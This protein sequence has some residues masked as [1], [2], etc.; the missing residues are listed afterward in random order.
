MRDRGFKNGMLDEFYLFDRVVHK[1]EIEKL[2][3]VSQEINESAKEYLFTRCLRAK[4][5]GP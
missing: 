3:G 5:N 1:S 2:A 4:C